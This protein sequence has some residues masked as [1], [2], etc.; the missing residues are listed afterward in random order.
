M[1]PGALSAF[2]AVLLKRLRFW[3]YCRYATRAILVQFGAFIDRRHP[4]VHLVHLVQFYSKDLI[5]GY[6]AHMHLKQI[7]CRWVHLLI[8]D[9]P[10]CTR[11]VHV[12]HL[13]HCYLFF[14]Q[15]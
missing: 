5:F 6:I 11:V 2:G 7:S 3:L 9:T 12:V 13:V 15:T 10:W 14:L 8:A 4:M 1:P